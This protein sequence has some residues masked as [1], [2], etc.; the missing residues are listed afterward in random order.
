MC[1]KAGSMIATV[2]VDLVS[3]KTTDV[4]LILMYHFVSQGVQ[5]PLWT[6]PLVHDTDTAVTAAVL[7]VI[8]PEAKTPGFSAGALGYFWATQLVV[9]Q[10]TITDVVCVVY[11]CVGRPK[12]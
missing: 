2:F 4:P 12:L 1:K 11:V 10:V 8:F 7:Y 3:V 9:K 6:K 5:K